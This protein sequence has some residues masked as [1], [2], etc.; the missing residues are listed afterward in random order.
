MKKPLLSVVINTKNAG[1][2]LEQC[3]HSIAVLDA[4]LVIV[5]MQSTDNTLDIAK[6]HHAKIYT[7]KDIG[8]ADPARNYALSKA[9]GEW[10]LV[11]DADEF[12][13]QELANYILT[14]IKDID[15]DVYS[16]PRK[17]IIFNQWIQH[18]GWWPDYQ[19]RLFKN[20]TVSWQVGVHKQP[21][22]KGTHKRIEAKEIYAIE[23]SNYTS[24]EEFID[25]LQRYTSLTANE[26]LSTDNK[27]AQP[28]ISLQAIETFKKEFLSRLFDRNGLADKSH[29]VVLSLLQSFYELTTILKIWEKKG[30]EN[31]TFSS[32]AVIKS[33]SSFS[34]DLNYWI[35]DYNIKQASG[36]KKIYWK[37]RK[38]MKL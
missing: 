33:L 17:N 28:D 31:D 34:R 27:I 16:L 20:G 26:R 36:F 2:T 5:D 18:T 1:K 38:K 11:L 6:Q 29:G 24:I 12:I 9:H 21:T 14:T 15:T 4:E 19:I 13:S 7:Y 22:I 25:K 35:A 8:Y 3:L 30:L 37:M 10:I 23:H 32:A